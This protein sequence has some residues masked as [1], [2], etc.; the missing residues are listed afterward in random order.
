MLDTPEEIKV[1][2]QRLKDYFGVFENGESNFRVVWSD[3]LTEKRLTDQT[4]S[5]FK[6][7]VPIM[8]EVP[9]YSYIKQ[10]YILERI[11][12]V[13]T[14][15]L[16]ELTTKLS[17][18]PIWVFEDA[19]GNALPPIWEAVNILIRTL[20]DQQL[21]KKGPYKLPE[22][23]GNTTEEIEARVEGLEKV[24]FANETK[25]GDALATGS[26]V[27]AGTYRRNDTRFNDNPIKIH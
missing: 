17:Y 14:S 4:D 7:T 10:R 15:Q 12:P 9:K 24:L 16:G 27:G 21:Y 8:Q 19:F 11:V 3:D 18:E 13:P 23:E 20:L 25:I 22:G 26:A 5:G 1:I 2:N 6:L